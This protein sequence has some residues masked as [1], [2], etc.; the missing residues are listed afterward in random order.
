VRLLVVIAHLS[1]TGLGGTN[2]RGTTCHV[3]ILT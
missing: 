2:N 1:D 3:G